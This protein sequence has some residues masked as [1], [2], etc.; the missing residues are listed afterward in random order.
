[1]KLAPLLLAPMRKTRLLLLL[2]ILQSCGSTTDIS[3]ESAPDFDPQGASIDELLRAAENTAGVE[4]AEL[5]VLALEALI[6]EGN[7]DRAA[8]Q[9]ALLNNLANYPEHLQLRASLLDARL[10]LN[11]DRI[12]DALAILSSTDTA[13][14]ESRPE[15]L[16]EYLLLLGL[17]YQEN[18]QYGDALSAYLRLGNANENNPRANI[19]VHNEIWDAI[20]SFSLVQLNN[21]ANTADSYQSRGWVELAR[22]V[23]SEAYSIRSQLDAIT[24]WRRIWSQ[25]PAAQQLP[26]QLEKL[27]QAWEQR[28]KHIALILPLQ[29]SAGRAIQ[30]GFLSAYYAALDVSRD[31]PRISVFDSSNQTAIY[32]LYDAAVA[33]GADLIIGPLYKQLVNQL[34]Q[35]HELPVPTL[36]LNYADESNSSSINLTQFGLAPEDE[37]EQAVEL[38]WQAGHRNAAII[39]PQSSDYQRLQQA[40]ANSWTGRGGNLVSQSTFSGD[41]DYADVIKRLIAIDS[42]EQRR[43]RLVQL[44]PRSSVEFTPRRR[45]DIDFIFLIA[46]P[47]EGRQIKPTLAFYYAGDIPV[48]ALPSIYDGLDNQSANQDLNGIIFT[49]APWILTN[50]D[51]LK[52]NTASSLRPAQGPVQRFRAMGIDSFRLY[53]R[54]QQFD[55]EDIISLRGATGI[56]SMDDNGR[57]H[58]RLEV[59]RFVDGKATLQ[60]SPD[61]TSD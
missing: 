6:E 41:N 28:P 45:D 40:F 44:L 39:T 22:V 61:A 4:S 46:N 21:F 24:Q 12:A 17:A 42:S 23:T 57:I 33:S 7:L 55:E 8:R 32:L 18:E 29:D 37:I 31:V 3:E 56:L 10:A 26:L 50:Y 36:A 30:E 48:Y 20:N 38:A 49:D 13:G 58:R 53:S 27:E 34:Q 59:A 47:R 60:E 1:M 54:L 2:I 11:T 52:S 19:S 25:H 15:L 35:L 14:L 16:Q 51:P 5:R 9:R 43:D